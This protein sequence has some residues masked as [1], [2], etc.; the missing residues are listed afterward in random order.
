MDHPESFYKIGGRG[1]HG[2]HGFALII[3]NINWIKDEEGKPCMSDRD[4]TDVTPEKGAR[5]CAAKLNNSL[6][7]IGYMVE[8]R[9]NLTSTE[10][11][12]ELEKASSKIVPADDSFICYISTHG[13]EDGLYGVDGR[14][15]TRKLKSDGTP[16]PDT[17]T[18]KQKPVPIEAFSKILEPDVC[19]HF[20]HKPKIFFIDACRGGE[21]SEPTDDPTIMLSIAAV[22]QPEGPSDADLPQ[23]SGVQQIISPELM[24]QSPITPVTGTC[25]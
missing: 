18:L 9:E 15:H 12:V 7:E 1:R 17:R 20:S 11:K 25:T 16:E 8:Y 22:K 14:P 5:A 3:N 23:N 10:M 24:T 2:R 4:G 6:L 21:P 19:K 13:D